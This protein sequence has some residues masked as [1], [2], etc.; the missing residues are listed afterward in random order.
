MLSIRKV[1]ALRDE[2]HRRCLAAQAA[3]HL[4]VGIVVAVQK[5]NRNSRVSEPAHLAN[6]KQPSIE[7]LPVPVVNVTGDHH[8]IDLLVDG[9]GDQVVESVPSRSFLVI[10]KLL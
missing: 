10:F 1:S 9:L 4:A 8:E 6:E 7:V 5:V 2:R 3:R